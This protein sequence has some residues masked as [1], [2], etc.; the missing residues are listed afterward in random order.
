MTQR[1]DHIVFLKKG[2]YLAPKYS[3]ANFD[4]LLIGITTYDV[5]VKTGVWHSHEKP[6][7]SF[8]L[9]GNNTEYRKEKT[10]ERTAGSIDFYHSGEIHKNVYSKFPSKH[11]SIEL[12]RDFLLNYGYTETEV[13]LAVKKN[14]DAVFTF[15]KLMHEATVNDL[16]SKSAVEMLFIAFMENSLRAKNEAQFPT[17]IKSVRD[18]LNDRWN[19]NISL[20]EL[21]ECVNVHPT[22]ISKYFR[23][24][25]SC[26]LG[27]YIRKLKVRHS[28]NLLHTSNYSLTETAHVCGFADQSHFTRV[29]KSCTGYLPKHYSKV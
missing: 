5:P 15:I 25:F 13:E 1:S 6:L 16:H 8:V 11:I 24:Y 28:I 27:E 10:I 26:T 19:E 4:D 9:Y 21:S 17:W 3:A 20:T 14:S 2:H 23:K 22:S 18:I 12:D 29:F 7:I